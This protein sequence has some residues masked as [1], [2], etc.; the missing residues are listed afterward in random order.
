MLEKTF[1]DWVR[2]MQSYNTPGIPK[3]LIVRRLIDGKKISAEDQ[4]EYWSEVGM[5]S[6]PV[7]HSRPDIANTTTELS[8]AN[9]GENLAAF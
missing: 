8:K 2:K 9:D 1:V 7:K 6:F 5:L 4:K 3:F